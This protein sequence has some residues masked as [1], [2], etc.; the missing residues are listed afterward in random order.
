MTVCC[1]L[2]T[3]HALCNMS[4]VRVSVNNKDYGVTFYDSSGQEEFDVLRVINYKQ[5]DVFLICFSVTSQ[6]SL[7]HVK[8]LVGY[9]RIIVQIISYISN[10]AKFV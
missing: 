6:S 10:L 3:L 4:K 1:L 7:E 2:Q 9:I 5:A 8:T